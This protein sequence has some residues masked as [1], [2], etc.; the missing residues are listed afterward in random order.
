MLVFK[1]WL[2]FSVQYVC[3]CSGSGSFVWVKNIDKTEVC[4]SVYMI[5]V[6]R[7]YLSVKEL[8]LLLCVN[9]K[10]LFVVISMDSMQWLEGLL[11]LLLVELFINLS[12]FF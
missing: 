9:Y 1:K 7:R 8:G 5:G 12:S 10:E 11:L 2:K 4:V 6:E 3:S